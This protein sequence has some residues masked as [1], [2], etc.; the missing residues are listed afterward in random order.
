MKVESCCL[1]DFLPGFGLGPILRCEL[2]YFRDFRP[3]QTRE[4]IFQIIE[5][6]EAVPAA[7]SRQRVNHGAAFP[8]P[9]MPDEQ[10]VFLSK[11]AG[12]DRIFSNS[13][14]LFHKTP[15]NPT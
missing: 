1:S 15:H 7:T 14:P 9:G 6:I 8:G 3:R 10:P 13:R 12:V 4:Q 11:S 5:S 2:I